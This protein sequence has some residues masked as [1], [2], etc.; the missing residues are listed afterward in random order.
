MQ[1]GWGT[2]AE[3]RNSLIQTQVK[4][5]IQLSYAW[6]IFTIRLSFTLSST[7][8]QSCLSAWCNQQFTWQ[9][10]PQ[11]SESSYQSRI[12][13]GLLELSSY[14]TNRSLKRPTHRRPLASCGQIPCQ[15]K[16]FNSSVWSQPAL[17]SLM[18]NVCLSACRLSNTYYLKARGGLM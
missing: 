13:Q 14:H 11:V 12:S 18:W 17:V 5:L 9:G 4:G 16:V 1:A 6:V 7:N 10:L 3:L 15:S 8:L 2:G